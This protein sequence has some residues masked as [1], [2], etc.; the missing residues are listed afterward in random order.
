M[1]RADVSD[2]FIISIALKNPVLV[3]PE[4]FKTHRV[5]RSN[6]HTLQ[7]VMELC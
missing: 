3:R 1:Y 7:L 5:Q 6:Y 2:I 4:N